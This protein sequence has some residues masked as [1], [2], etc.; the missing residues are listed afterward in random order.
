MT[1]IVTPQMSGKEL[2]E[3]LTRSRPRL[4]VLFLSGY[5]G[6]M[7]VHHGVLDTGT[8]FLR[9]PFRTNAKVR[10]ILDRP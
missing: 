9:K 4:R 6:N 5:T 8:D 10:E 1:D 2:A 7:I 3:R